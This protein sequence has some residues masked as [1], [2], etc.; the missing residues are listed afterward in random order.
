ML[1]CRQVVGLGTHVARSI[2]RMRVVVVLALVACTTSDQTDSLVVTKP[3][4]AMCATSGIEIDSGRDANHDAV[5]EPDEITSSSVVCTRSE[6]VRVV[7]EPAGVNCPNGGQAIESGEDANGNGAL[8]EAEVSSTSYVCNG[9]NG[10]RTLVRVDDAGAT[11]PHG[12]SAVHTG[13]DTNGN[14]ILDDAEITSTSYL[15]NAANGQNALIRFDPEPEGANCDHG[16]TAVSAGLDANGDGVLEDVEVQSTSYLCSVLP[17]P[18]TIDGDF[19]IESDIDLARLGGVTEITGDLIFAST[20]IT[21]IWIPNLQRVGGGVYCADP[22]STGP[23]PCQALTKIDFPSLLSV[24]EGAN[25]A[26]RGMFFTRA[27]LILSS[28]HLPALVSANRV[29]IDGLLAELVLPAYTM[30]G[31]ATGYNV[32]LTSLVLPKVTT[33]EIQVVSAPALKTI[34]TPSLAT[35]A[36]YVMTWLR[37][38]RSRR[39]SSPME[40]YMHR[41]P[42]CSASFRFRC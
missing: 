30:G 41:S 9:A 13:I 29:A 37:S 40:M 12:G 6:I 5:L 18:S 8:D 17:L 21:S 2:D 4:G 10:D 33:G 34:S 16:G 19:T 22:S 31:V 36:V 38:R 42:P 25:V 24:G 39:R 26:N 23:Q 20:A 7:I 32:N 15:C 35:G 11:C 27:Y 3:A 28:L 14:G 1:L